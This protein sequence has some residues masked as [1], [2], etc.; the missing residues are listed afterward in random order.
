M[1]DINVIEPS[2]SFTGGLG[3]NAFFLGAYIDVQGF[4][5]ITVTARGDIPP[6]LNTAIQFEWSTD[7]VNLDSTTIFGSD[8]QTQ[9]TVHGTVRAAFF[10]LRYTAGSTGQTNARVQTLLRTGP[11]NGSV[12]RLGLITGSPD[13]LDTNAMNFGKGIGLTNPTAFWGVSDSVTP[14][15]FYQIMVP[16]PNRSNLVIQL[17]TATT[18]SS[19]EI[20]LSNLFGDRRRWITVFNNT[21]RGNL[22]IKY[23]GAA[24][25][26]VYD[27]KVPPQHSWT[28]PQSWIGFGAIGGTLFGIWDFADGNAH[29]TE[30]I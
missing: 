7:G 27:F 12:S 24:T 17:I 13:A 15:Q 30:G 9:Q 28:M 10:R 11:Y 14:A 20:D 26:T 19:P 6:A 4:T 23:N 16:P 29:V 3:A 8:A 21:V 5:S 18:S 2:Q 22:F 1:A 25:T